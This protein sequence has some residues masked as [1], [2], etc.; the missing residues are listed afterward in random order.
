MTWEEHQ[1]CKVIIN[2]KT[3]LLNHCARLYSHQN[4]SDLI[5]ENGL[6]FHRYLCKCQFF[7]KMSVERSLLEKDD[8]MSDGQLSVF[9]SA[10]IEKGNL[11]PI[12][13]LVSC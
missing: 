11:K 2:A 7:N 6:L 12:L 3:F 5:D 9:N 1:V 13:G 10:S 8:K 4:A